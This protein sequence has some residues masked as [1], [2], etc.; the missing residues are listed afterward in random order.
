[1]DPAAITS[2][3][4]LEPF[5]ARVKETTD[6]L[7]WGTSNQAHGKLFQPEIH[8]YDPIATTLALAVRYDDTSLQALCWYDTPEFED[9]VRLA[10]SWNEQGLIEATPPSSEDMNSRWNAEQ[11]AFMDAQYLPTN[12]QSTSFP[13]IGN[14]FVTTPLLNTDGVLATLTGINADVEHPEHVLSL[15]EYLNTDEEIYRMICF[16]IEG[17]HYTASPENPQLVEPGPEQASWDPNTDWVFGNQFKAPYRNQA[18]ADAERWERERELNESAT[19]SAAIGFS[20]VTDEVRTEVASVTA[21]IA[22]HATLAL[23]GQLDATE[24]LS[25]LRAAVEQAGMPRI[26]EVTQQQLDTFRTA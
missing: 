26:L 16:G 21:A 9:A 6:L 11:T 12:P 20:L 23:T 3:A 18:D 14:T 25:N 22:E 4:E 19:P 5:L 13:T 10:R 1:M 8:G 15:L 7:P 17:T 2:F 24:A